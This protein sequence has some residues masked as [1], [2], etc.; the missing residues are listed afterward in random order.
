MKR[1]ESQRIA[2]EPEAAALYE[3]L[4]ARVRGQH[5]YE[6]PCIVAVPLAAG[7]EPFLRWVLEETLPGAGER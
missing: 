3:R 7:S 2:P 5:S 4:E 1:G 6:C